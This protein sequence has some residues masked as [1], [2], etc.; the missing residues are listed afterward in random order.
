MNVRDL[1]NT[2]VQAALDA[3]HAE[4]TAGIQTAGK[5]EFGDYQ[6]NGVMAAAKRQKRNPM[7]LAADVVGAL[8]LDDVADSIDIAGPGFLN[9]RLSTNF[10]A[11]N[12]VLGT[13]LL[14]AQDPP[15]HTV[16]DYS[17][18]NLAK[19]MHVGHL[20][21]TVIGDAV[22]RALEVL[23]HRVTRQNHVGD[24]GTQ[25]GM[26]LEYLEETDGANSASDELKDLEEFYRRSRERFTA[27]DAFAQRARAK[28][29][30]LQRGDENV[31]AQWRHFIDVSL[32]HCDEVYQHLGVTLSR[33]DVMA[34]SAYNED[35]NNVISSL[36]QQGLLTESDGAQCVFLDQF[37]KKDGEPLPVIVQKS[38]GGYLYATTDLAAIRYRT[39]KLGASRV[40]YF[41]DTRQVLHFKQVFAVARTAG[42][43]T[44]DAS[45]EHMPFGAMLGTDGKPFKTREGGVVHL[46]DLLNEAEQRA[47]ELVSEKNPT[48]TE[49]E[50]LE[51]ARVVGVGAVKYADLSKNRGSD[52]VFD[53]DQMLAFEGNTAPYLQYAYARIQSLFR[54]GDISVQSL[55][56]TLRPSEPA[57]RDLAI[58]LLRF[59]EN[60]ELVARDGYPHVLCAYLYD[61]TTKFMRFYEQCPI[62]TAQS[63]S[64]RDNRLRFSHRTAETLRAG[65]S[66]LGIETVD[67]M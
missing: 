66:L 62:L 50:R 36:A 46:T 35:L 10:I 43:T 55:D 54:R 32:S 67:R 40:L 65:L 27:D 56:G 19:E 18:P 4:G 6:A 41:T 17:S 47:F 25:F 33:A 45:L 37:K 30:A 7:E 2:R 48:L 28:V 63:L 57:E 15:Q 42:F 58:A 22:A 60:V 26:L 44:D 49:T 1:L 59:Q 3:C 61:L 5:P 21:S 52:Y 34:E 20:R 38:D 39:H 14:E 13:P 29:V 16:V 31:L 51:I 9:I 23:G 53:W 12:L 64:A 11:D 24:W 8:Q